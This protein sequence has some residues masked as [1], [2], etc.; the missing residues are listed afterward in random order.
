MRRRM[1]ITEDLEEKINYPDERWPHIILH[2]KLNDTLL[3]YIPLH[4][5]YA[6]QFMYV[7]EGVIQVK[8]ADNEIVIDQGEAAIY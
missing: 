6:L 4:W 7:T 2:T 8:I 3:G 1:I 5:H